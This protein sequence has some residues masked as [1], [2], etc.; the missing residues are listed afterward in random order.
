MSTTPRYPI[1][2]VHGIA[3]FDALWNP[4][5]SFLHRRVA[6][7][8]RWF[9]R[10]SYFRNVATHLRAHGYTVYHAN[11]SFAAGTDTCA[12]ELK[13]QVL[14]ALEETGA[15]RAVIIAHSMGGLVARRMIVNH[16]MDCFVKTLCMI[17]T[18]NNG[19]A[20]ADWGKINRGDILIKWLRQYLDLTGFLDLTTDSC[21]RFNY[22]A[23][24]SE[25]E[26]SVRYVTVAASQE[27]K[28]VFLPLQRSHDII[29][30]A[31][32]AND[33]LVSKSSQQW[34]NTLIT[35]RSFKAVTQINFDFQADHFNECGWWDAH[36]EEKRASYEARVLEMYLK[37]AAEC[38]N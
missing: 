11:L 22:E 23:L 19:T 34:T 25:A 20:F 7:L 13:T 31:E 36:E 28:E 5:I 17:G 14:D 6:R 3:R 29:Y 12:R 33:G 38:S 32:G 27:R 16:A 1:V 8:D 35:R 26:N 24:E 18:P 15:R 21:R 9:D 37:L 10:L 2:L 30:A 4:L